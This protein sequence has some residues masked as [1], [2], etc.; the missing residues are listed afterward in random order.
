MTAWTDERIETL[1]KLW[2][3]G[4]SASQIAGRIGGVSRNAV[5]GKVSR[6]KL[7]GRATTSRSRHRSSP[8]WHK[9]AVAAKIRATVMALKNVMPKCAFVPVKEE[10]T[11]MKV[12][13]V[14]EV[15]PLHVDLLD[16]KP[17]MCR[18]P[19]GDGP[20]TFCGCKTK[21]GSSYCEFHHKMSRQPIVRRPRP[22]RPEPVYEPQRSSVA[23]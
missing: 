20:Y 2:A 11:P 1:K 19:Y 12:E 7:S 15:K 17:D 6:L 21:E 22:P 13:S 18:W 5:I 16:L 8:D 14:D 3:E 10:S 9:R 23:A 4:L